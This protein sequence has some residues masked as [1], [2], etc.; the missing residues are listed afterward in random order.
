MTRKGRA[1]IQNAG[2]NTR[3]IQGAAGKKQGTG[4]GIGRP[5]QLAFRINRSVRSSPLPPALKVEIV[6]S[7]ARFS[8]NQ[9]PEFTFKANKSCK[10]VDIQN[11]AF[12]KI[13]DAVYDG[14][15][16]A[17]IPSTAIKISGG[18]QPP[19]NQLKSYTYKLTL[20]ADNNGLP[21]V[22][23]D[24][25]DATL[26]FTA[27]IGSKKE[28]VVL[29][30]PTF[31]VDV[32]NP[33]LTIVTQ[34]ASVS[35]VNEP[36]IVINAT[37]IDGEPGEEAT[38]LIK[39]KN[40]TTNQE[41]AVKKTIEDNGN[42]T[43]ELGTLPDGEYTFTEFTLTDLA[44]NQ[45]NASPNDFDIDTQPP[46]LTLVTP[47]AE[48][49]DGV[50]EFQL[51]S[52]KSGTINFLG[53]ATFSLDTAT[54]AANTDTDIGLSWTGSATFFDGKYSGQ[55]IKVEDDYGNVAEL[56]LP[57]FTIDT[58]APSS[59]N[60]ITLLNFNEDNTAQ[61]S[62]VYGRTGNT[63]VCS[64]VSF[65]FEVPNATSTEAPVTEAVLY[66]T[67]NGG[68]ATQV[69]GPTVIREV[70][71]TNTKFTVTIKNESGFTEGIYGSAGTYTG[72]LGEYSIQM[73][74]AAGNFVLGTFAA[75]PAFRVDVT[76]PQLSQPLSIGITNTNT[77][78]FTFQ[79]DKLGT[80]TCNDPNL[81]NTVTPPNALPGNYILQFNTLTDGEVSGK[82]ITLTDIAGNVSN[83]INIPAF[84]VDTVAP[85][86]T[87]P[88][89]GIGTT[90]DSTP[91][92]KLRSTE[93]G[94]ISYQVQTP[95]VIELGSPTVI[96]ANTDTDIT[97]QG[98]SGGTIPVGSYSGEKIMV[99]DAAGN[100]GELILPD[101]E[102]TN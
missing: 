23:G 69:V 45:D 30:I 50:L 90:S 82:T 97:I 72:A 15:P 88:E 74:D 67:P 99:T 65:E 70:G 21:L 18:K 100:V 80:V 71:E 95:N 66:Y 38:L 46:V 98:L 76:A 24:Y 36:T 92:F 4:A 25:D 78:Q 81:I 59:P 57:D 73:G 41:F 11:I 32:N 40:T 27:M 29:K 83:T 33:G 8:N 85:V 5:P 96:T 102:I 34:V 16:T 31:T 42:H 9:N 37:N 44:G 77:P 13:N 93:A 49:T 20:S 12:W 35:N 62:A 89:G 2:R 14:L 53:P 60:S 19:P 101:F 94:N 87:L 75:V 52:S 6:K 22:A 26:T 54:I 47:I 58:V 48:Y 68:V 79:T 1:G 10:F 91:T 17:N 39:F 63:N 55:K 7:V 43:I 3:D 28:T 84:T 51:K 64:E 86:L 56:I 61:P